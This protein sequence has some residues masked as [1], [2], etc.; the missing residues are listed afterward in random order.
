[1]FAFSPVFVICTSLLPQ[2]K[3]V[4]CLA[5]HVCQFVCKITFKK[6]WTDFHGG[7]DNTDYHLDPG[8]FFLKEISL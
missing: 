6:L 2:P 3:E 5:A 1:M 8:N 7:G 4:I